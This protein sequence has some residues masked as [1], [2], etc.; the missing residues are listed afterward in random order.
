MNTSASLIVLGIYYGLLTTFSVGP[1]QLISAR[2]FL[3]EGPARD[4]DI[5]RTIQNS[6]ILVTTI[7][8]V[9]ISNIIILIS[10]YFTPI[11][12]LLIKPFSS[13]IFLFVYIYFY[14]RRVSVFNR[15]ALT[16]EEHSFNY[17][18]IFNT[19]LDI[20][21]VQFLNP[22]I[23]PT[24]VFKRLLSVFLFRYSQMPFFLSGIVIGWIGGQFL[25]ILSTYYL[26]IRLEKD[27]GIVYKFLKVIIHRFFPPIFLAMCFLFLGRIPLHLSSKKISIEKQNL[28]SKIYSNFFVSRDEMRRPLRLI[29]GSLLEEEIEPP[30]LQEKN[31]NFVFKEETQNKK[32]DI[33]KNQTNKALWNKNNFSQYI[34][35]ACVSDGKRKLS[36]TYPQ[37]LLV[38][39]KKFKTNLEMQ[40]LCEEKEIYISAEWI[41]NK[42]SRKT[43]LTQILLNR[44]EMLDKGNFLDSISEKKMT[45][46]PII[47]QETEQTLFKK[48][49]SRLNFKNQT[50]NLLFYKDSS[51][52][53]TESDLSQFENLLESE[54]LNISKIKNELQLINPQNQIKNLLTIK[55]NSFDLANI[56]QKQTQNQDSIELLGMYKPMPYWKNN[57]IRAL[58]NNSTFDKRSHVVSTS[59]NLDFINNNILRNVLRNSLQNQRRKTLIWNLNQE[60][61][62][63]PLMLRVEKLM[64]NKTFEKLWSFFSFKETNQNSTIR[65]IKKNTIGKQIN[66]TNSLKP[67]I[68]NFSLLLQSLLRKYVTLPILISFKNCITFILF[69]EINW[70][71]DWSDWKKETYEYD[72]GVKKNDESINQF[73]KPLPWIMTRESIPQ[74]K[75]K[76]PFRLRLLEPSVYAHDPYY[77]NSSYLTV[78]GS[79]TDVSFGKIKQ[80][81]AFFKPISKI[82]RLYLKAIQLISIK[83]IKKITSSF[84]FFGS[85][86]KVLQQY[87]LNYKNAKNIQ[88]DSLINNNQSSQLSNESL[89]INTLVANNEHISLLPINLSGQTDNKGSIRSNLKD[90][91]QIGMISYLKT[92]S[93]NIKKEIEILQNKLNNR[94]NIQSIYNTK[95]VHTNL[96]TQYSMLG[97]APVQ[98]NLN[99]DVF[100]NVK[101]LSKESK[102]S[103]WYKYFQLKN[104]IIEIDRM[105]SKYIVK[106]N[107]YFF[108]FSN[109]LQKII[110]QTNPKLVQFTRKIIKKYK[111]FI[112]Q[113]RR[114]LINI[115]DNFYFN[116]L[117]FFNKKDSK[118][119]R[120]QYMS[121]DIIVRSNTLNGL[122]QAFIFHK[123]WQTKIINTFN[124]NSLMSLWSSEKYLENDFQSILKNKGIFNEKIPSIF[125]TNNWEE[126]IHEMPR[127]TPSSKVW[128]NIAPKMWNIKIEEKLKKDE[129][130]KIYLKPQNNQA[131]INSIGKEFSY[132][133]ALL[134]K[135][136]KLF[137]RWKFDLIL[138]NY[139]NNEKTSASTYQNLIQLSQTKVDTNKEP[140]TF[141]FN[142]V[143]IESSLINNEFDFNN[144]YEWGSTRIRQKRFAP[145]LPFASEDIDF[146]NLNRNKNI[147]LGKK[148]ETTLIDDERILR[149]IVSPFFRFINRQQ[150]KIGFNITELLLSDILLDESLFLLNANGF[151]PENIFLLNKIKELRVLESLNITKNLNEYEDTVKTNKITKNPSVTLSDKLFLLKN[152]S[153]FSE[154]NKKESPLWFNKID[155]L[156]YDRILKRL[157][158]PIHHLEDLACINR[159]SIDSSNQSR[160]STL[161]IKMY[162]FLY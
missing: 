152:I 78:F 58:D 17:I 9:I 71:K 77:D 154:L 85:K 132:H 35:E 67:A 127:Y 4:L 83:E 142:D 96:L 103:I 146:D 26:F 25:F 79:E 82:F 95:L 133:K 16:R 23:F 98:V 87:F 27:T 92:D 61:T 115:I 22:F 160:F 20:I 60:R 135:A 118:T 46:L 122:S 116:I 32:Q 13:S 148:P 66:S 119:S 49:D 105:C 33:K 129:T 141:I 94:V 86:N 104:K 34:F 45:S 11:S 109:S 112:V 30:V 43:Q 6:K 140:E 93:V 80:Q 124:F 52:L 134:G 136:N 38:A 69:K 44:M 42:T 72:D 158:W 18:D 147:I 162:P 64:R 37:S 150:E 91:L 31:S 21:L 153:C 50:H 157:L 2:N 65:I 70:T 76:N 111:Y 139:I 41:L 100:F 12:S 59:G 73:P 8:A 102:L 15:D 114:D 120:E 130:L 161:R 40:Q 1:Y 55:P 108:S 10:I 156:K 63:T 97:R 125:T 53:S 5:Y 110:N 123:I 90:E 75:I 81:P 159:F 57:E 84:S 89:T 39:E 107:K 121:K 128:T 47:S 56:N 48:I 24:P 151:L 51:W 7:S 36:Y 74:I 29:D 68:R 149:N 3:L 14:W 28:K 117:S 143:A 19:F 101:I 54:I 137:K 99:E 145:Y 88:N 126:W 144:H 62:K 106:G 138:Q 155:S 113:I 131:I